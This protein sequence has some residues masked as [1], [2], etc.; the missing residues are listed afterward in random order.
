ME[1][2]LNVGC[3]ITIIYYCT[4]HSVTCTGFLIY[5]CTYCF[6]CIYAYIAFGFLIQCYLGCQLDSFLRS[7]FLLLN[8]IYVD[9][10]VRHFCCTVRRYSNTSNSLHP[11]TSAAGKQSLQNISVITHILIYIFH[12]DK[13]TSSDSTL[14]KQTHPEYHTPIT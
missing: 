4:L 1:Y 5:R 9:L 11:L 14:P 13:T 8:I 12:K 3:N 6:W 2:I 10:L 7:W